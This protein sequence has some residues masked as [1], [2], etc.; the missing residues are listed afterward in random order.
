[1]DNDA[2]LT[3]ADYETVRSRRRQFASA[4]DI[5]TG[6][7]DTLN[8]AGNSSLTVN[9]I[10]AGAMLARRAVVANDLTGRRIRL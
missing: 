4:T 9:D 6:A 7:N 5:S 10:D 8:I 2:R 1:M 3:F